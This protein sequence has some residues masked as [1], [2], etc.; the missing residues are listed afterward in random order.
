MTDPWFIHTITRR[1]RTGITSDHGDPV[2]G[3]PSTF[4]ARVVKRRAIVRNQNGEEVVA[5]SRM[6]TDVECAYDD[7]FWLPS[8]AGEGADDVNNPDA[9]RSPLSLE[10]GEDETGFQ[11]LCVVWFA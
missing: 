11:K 10:S 2:Y 7:V 5:G 4:Q 6:L 8:I 9:G 3:D 1:R